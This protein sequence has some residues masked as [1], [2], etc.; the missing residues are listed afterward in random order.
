M[1]KDIDMK[2]ILENIFKGKP[3]YRKPCIYLLISFEYIPNELK[4][5]NNVNKLS[6]NELA[7]DE[8]CAKTTILF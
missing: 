6:M 4:P 8:E 3:Y 7:L 2:F 5:G 1:W